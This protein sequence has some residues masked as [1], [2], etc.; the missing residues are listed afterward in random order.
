METADYSI[1]TFTTGFCFIREKVD[2][3]RKCFTVHI[4]FRGV[5]THQAAKDLMDNALILLCI[6]KRI[7]R[8]DVIGVCADP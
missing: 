4:H 8:F 3:P 1:S 7:I 6:M 5:K 2:L